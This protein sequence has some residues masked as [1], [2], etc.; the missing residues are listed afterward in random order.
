VQNEH[1]TPAAPSPTGGEG[2]AEP[3]LDVVAI[4]NALVDVLASVDD[5]ALGRLRLV[6][7][8]MALVQLDRAEEIYATMGTTVEASG[9]SAANTMAGVAAQGGARP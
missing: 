6:K 3:R 9:G 5:A 4:G 2:G 1:E 7:G 8:T